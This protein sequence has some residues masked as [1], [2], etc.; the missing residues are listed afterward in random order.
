MTLTTKFYL[1]V[2]ILILGVCALGAVSIWNVSALWQSTRAQAAEYDALDHADG[3][4]NQVTWLRDVLRGADARSY[5]DIQFFTP[6]QNEVRAVV[7][8][9]ELAAK[10]D[11][12]DAAAELALAQA[13]AQH[14]EAAIAASAAAP[15]D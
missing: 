4:S 7:A 12:G 8:S 14:M 11:D 5:R 13:A 10:T 1:W 2:A 6:I 3:V 15:A 9:L